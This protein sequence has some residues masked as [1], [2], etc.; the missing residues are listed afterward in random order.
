MWPQQLKRSMTVQIVKLFRVMYKAISM[1]MAML[2]VV[3]SVI[4]AKVSDERGY[5]NFALFLAY[6][7]FFFG[8][9][10]RYYFYRFTLEQCG[11]NIIFKF[12][13][14]CLYRDIRLHSHITVGLFTLLGRC[15]IKDNVLLGSHINITSGNQQHKVVIKDD[16]AIFTDGHREQVVV[17]HHVWVGNNAVILKS[18]D[19]NCIVGAGSVLTKETLKNGIYVGNPAQRLRDIDVE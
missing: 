14:C 1:L 8:E 13:S 18:I 19:K 16:E 15:T 7:P 9:K 2:C 10:L 12:G 6:M 3:P 4:F 17:G 5:Y 11:K